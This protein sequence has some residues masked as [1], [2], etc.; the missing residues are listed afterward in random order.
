LSIF[1]VTFSSLDPPPG[2]AIAEWNRW[3]GVNADASLNQ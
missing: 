3:T 2:A 1:S